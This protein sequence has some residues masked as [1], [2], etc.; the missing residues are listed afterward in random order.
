MG[1]QLL[2]LLEVEIGAELVNM[3]DLT[4]TE[5][6]YIVVV[7]TAFRLDAHQ[8]AN[9]IM[10]QPQP[11]VSQEKSGHTSRGV[12]LF[13]VGP[14]HLGVVLGDHL[15]LTLRHLVSPVQTNNQK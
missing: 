3:N 4:S 10:L 8:I 13:V 15:A 9:F 14:G 6:I 1:E 12:H 7:T 5:K 11:P 2:L